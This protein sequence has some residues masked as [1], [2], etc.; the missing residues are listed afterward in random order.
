VRRPSQK[1]AVL[2]VN[3]GA[4]MN[5]KR[6]LWRAWI[7]VTV[8]WV[9]GTGT[10]AYFLMVDAVA[11][12]YQW[13]VLL[14]KDVK[15]PWKH[16]EDLPIYEIAHWP[17]KEGLSVAFNPL[18]YEYA[19]QWNKDVDAGKTILV[20]FPDHSKLYLNAQLTKEDQ[21]YLSRAFWDQRWE[22]WAT[23]GLPFA[24]L[25][26]LPPIVVL[27]LGSFMLWVARGFA[28]D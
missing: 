18:D 6:G 16:F 12:N 2:T 13:L 23:I 14:R 28:H 17:S 24:G 4:T 5:V 26:V 10:L 8:L 1:L 21:T 11:K 7:F 9:L 3:C 20:D 25:V 22:R 27:M 15:E 19:S